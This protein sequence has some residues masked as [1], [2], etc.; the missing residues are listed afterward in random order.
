MLASCGDLAGFWHKQVWLVADA[1]MEFKIFEPDDESDVQAWKIDP[2]PFLP[3]ATVADAVTAKLAKALALT[4]PVS[5]PRPTKISL[6][7]IVNSQQ[8]LREHQLWT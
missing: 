1:P 6:Q 8:G 2:K 7:Q 4:P 3:Q 5:E